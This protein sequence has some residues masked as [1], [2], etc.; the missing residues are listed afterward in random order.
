[1][2][3]GLFHTH[4]MMRYFILAVL[5]LAILKSIGGWM[6]KSEYD[7]FD[8]RLAFFAMLFVHLQIVLGFVM[9]FLSPKVMIDNMALAMKTPLV[10]YYTVEHVLMMLIVAA[11][12]TIG[13]V[14]SKKKATDLQKHKV[15]S[16]YYGLSLVIILVT[17][18]VM[19]PM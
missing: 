9:Y 12:I 7:K 19:M 3:T 16:I 6:R 2:Y 10:R 1:M 13:R 11:L 5:I 17:V 15:I 14:V 8:N 4:S 18:Y